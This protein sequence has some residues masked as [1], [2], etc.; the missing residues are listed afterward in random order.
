MTKEQWKHIWGMKCLGKIRQFLWRFTH[1]SLAVNRN[2]ERRGVEVDVSCI[3]CSRQI[4]DG[5]HLFFK[6]KCV[7]PLWRELLLENQRCV[8]AGMGSAKDIMEHALKLEEKVQMKVALLL[9]LWWSERNAVREGDR[10]RTTS[11]LAYVIHK[12]AEEF[13]ELNKK[14]SGG[15]MRRVQQWCRPPPN[16]LKVNTDGAFLENTRKGGWGYVI[17]D[18]EGDVIGA[19]AGRLE[20]IRDAFQAEVAASIQGIRASV[21]KGITRVILETDSL[22]LKHALENNS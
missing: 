14:P 10:R 20:H 9:Y 13:I 19:G 15:Q 11:D 8:L 5:G 18:E 16:W 17:R 4:E 1:N 2:L 6:C 21:Q 7:K 3:M 12:N 22:T